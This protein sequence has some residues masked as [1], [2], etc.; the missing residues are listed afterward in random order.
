MASV[1]YL[2]RHKILVLKSAFDAKISTCLISGLYS[3]YPSNAGNYFVCVENFVF[4]LLNPTFLL[5]EFRNLFLLAVSQVFCSCLRFRGAL[6][7]RDSSFAIAKIFFLE[8]ICIFY[9]FTFGWFYI[10]LLKFDI[11][12]LWIPLLFRLTFT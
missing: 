6:K 5:F 10:K 7:G 9:L 2:T 11:D 1:I 8:Y 3:K 12:I 4:E